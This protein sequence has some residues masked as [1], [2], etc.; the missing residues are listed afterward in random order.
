MFGK[1][2]EMLGLGGGGDATPKTV[3]AATVEYKGYRI[4]PAPYKAGTGSQTAGSIEK[5]FPDGVKE[6][7]FIRADTNPSEDGAV[8]MTLMKAR[9]II[10]LEGDRI[11][12]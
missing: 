5:D 9:Q 2:K 6:H 12:G 1:I 4:K 11:F 10:D 7:K 8:E 3:A